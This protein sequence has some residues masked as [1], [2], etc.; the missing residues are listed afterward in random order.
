MPS[1]EYYHRQAGT[2]LALSSCT[3][4]PHLSAQC[5]ALAVEY[6]LLAETPTADPTTDR[7]AGA[8]TPGQAETL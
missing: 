2:L 4:D 1:S 8:G 7:S 3:N 5:R 6:R